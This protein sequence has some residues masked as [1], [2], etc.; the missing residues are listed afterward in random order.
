VSS[1]R[2]GEVWRIPAP[3]KLKSATLVDPQE[4]RRTV[5][6]REGRAL[7]FGDQAGFYQLL[8]GGSEPP[9]TFAANLVDALESDITPK[10]SLSIQGQN[11]G[12]PGEFKAGVRRELW[13]YLVLGALALSL[14]EW[15]SYHRRLTV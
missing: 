1:F 11:A 6:V 5:P 2:T 9:W 15:F 12:P 13:L 10:D 14:A 3:S 8:T 4:Q 7:T